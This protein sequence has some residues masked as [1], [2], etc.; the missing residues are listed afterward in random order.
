M[1][2]DPNPFRDSPDSD[3]SASPTEAPD[4]DTRDFTADE[5]TASAGKSSPMSDDSAGSASDSAT[6]SNAPDAT[7]GDPSSQAGIDTGNATGT[8]QPV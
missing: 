5:D 4:N 8:T 3:R 2:T 7:A 1:D 6:T